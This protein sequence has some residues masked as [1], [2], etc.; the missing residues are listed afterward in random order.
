MAKKTAVT[1]VDKRP[2]AAQK[3]AAA[4]A[5]ARESAALEAIVRGKD[6]AATQAR[7][8]EQAKRANKPVPGMLRA[9]A[10]K[11]RA[12]DKRAAD[13][14]AASLKRLNAVCAK[15]ASAKTKPAPAEK[16]WKDWPSTFKTFEGK[17]VSLPAAGPWHS[18]AS[19]LLALHVAIVGRPAPEGIHIDS[20]S[21]RIKAAMAGKLQTGPEEPTKPA[22]A[23]T[24]VLLRTDCL[25]DELLA[26]LDALAAQTKTDRAGCACSIFVAAL[27]KVKLAK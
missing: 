9:A 18:E 16:T 8:R 15:N 12:E 21:K 1:I 7:I 20:V 5:K 10:Q 17:V 25:D 19:E 26:K 24:R 3:A 14:R 4:A 23:S 27:A 6:E 11:A 2:T 13:A 22:A